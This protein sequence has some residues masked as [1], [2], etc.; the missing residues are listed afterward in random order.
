MRI[1]QSMNSIPLQE[2]WKSFVVSS[3]SVA[4]G[5]RKS[6]GTWGSL[7]MEIYKSLDGLQ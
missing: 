3:N 5:T 7:R 6:F 2:L 1:K 4:S